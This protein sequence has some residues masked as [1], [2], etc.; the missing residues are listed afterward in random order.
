MVINCHAAIFKRDAPAGE[1]PSRTSDAPGSDARQPHAVDVR[2]GPNPAVRAKRPGYP[3]FGWRTTFKQDHHPPWALGVLGLTPWSDLT[4]LL[5]DHAE[6]IE[7]RRDA[8][9]PLA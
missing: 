3:S 8:H 1:P 2:S 4:C 9:P 6:P 7:A 5:A